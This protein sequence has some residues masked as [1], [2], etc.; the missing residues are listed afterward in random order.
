M[1]RSWD[2]RYGKSIHHCLWRLNNLYWLE[3]ILITENYVNKLLVVGSF[4]F[5]D[6][7]DVSKSRY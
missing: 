4:H 5:V 6:R 3:E 2:F 7:G 1:G